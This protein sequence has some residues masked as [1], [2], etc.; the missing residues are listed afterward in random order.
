[1]VDLRATNEKLRNRTNRIVRD[2]TGLDGIAADVL[3]D[4]CGRELKT[5]L[6]SQLAGVSAEE[7]RDRLRIANGRVRAAVGS[8]GRNGLAA[9]GAENLVLGIDGGGTQTIVFLASRT[10]DGGWKQLGRGEAGPSNRQVVGT[11]ASL[12]ALDEATERAFAAAGRPRQA[13][14]AAC[15]GLAGAGRP[16]DQDIVREWAA[17]THLADAVDVIEDAALLLAAGTPDGW[18]VA[19]V[20]GTGSMAFAR[21]ADGRTAR[22]GGWGPLLG[23]EGSG[24]AIA[25][26]GLRAAA[27]SA[28]GRTPATPLTEQLLTAYGLTRPEELIGVVYRGGDRAALAALAPVVLEAAEAGDPAADRIVRDAAGELAAA[29]AAAAAQLDLG[30]ALPVALAG[31]LLVSDSGYRKRVLAAFAERGLAVGPVALVTEPAEG[32]VRLTLARIGSVSS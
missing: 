14:R 3:L 17:R 1:M 10:S 4:R 16:G 30:L 11:L 2:A 28:D 29:A 19:I 32:A 21:S 27:R 15:L 20:A 12:A 6:V 5:A 23:D 25:I 26:A 7:A 8:Y 13:V 22:A 9:P 24:Y 18:G 31:G